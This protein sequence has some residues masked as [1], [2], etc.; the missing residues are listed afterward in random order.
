MI[1]VRLIPALSSE[2]R[3]N[4]LLGLVGR[5]AFDYLIKACN[6]FEVRC[7]EQNAAAPVGLTAK[8]YMANVLLFDLIY[9]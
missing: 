7:S 8:T 3:A 2:K 9:D 4:I 6:I 1:D 5:L